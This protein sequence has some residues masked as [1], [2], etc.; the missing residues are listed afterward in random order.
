MLDPPEKLSV[1]WSATQ[2]HTFSI[3]AEEV[4]ARWIPR[5][6]ALHSLLASPQEFVSALAPRVPPTVTKEFQSAT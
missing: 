1:M 2:F 5:K 3:Y 4:G 6:A